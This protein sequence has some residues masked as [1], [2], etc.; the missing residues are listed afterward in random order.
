[1]LVSPLDNW[2][3]NT[4]KF[5]LISV[6]LAA[7]ISKFHLLANFP[8]IWSTPD[9]IFPFIPQA[10]VAIGGSIFE[11]LLAVAL[12]IPKTTKG[13]TKTAMWMFALFLCTHFVYFLRD[14]PTSCAC[15]KLPQPVIN[16]FEHLNS[17]PFYVALA[18]CGLAIVA[19][20][21]T[22]C[23]NSESDVSN[24]TAVEIEH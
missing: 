15:F 8:A 19:S 10:F 2:V 1:M 12:L 17:F 16:R 18:G 7:S 22:R 14:V 5:I 24:P 11:L 4:A 23:S 13:A 3:R 21:R 9:V 6:L 20:L